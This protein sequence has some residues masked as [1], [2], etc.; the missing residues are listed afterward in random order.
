MHTYP[1][2]SS[3]NGG[4]RVPELAKDHLLILKKHLWTCKCCGFQSRPVKDNLYGYMVAVERTDSD[5]RITDFCLCALCHASHFVDHAFDQGKVTFIYLDRV[6]QKQLNVLTRT[7]MIAANSET[8]VSDAADDR[9]ND[10]AQLESHLFEQLPDYKGGQSDIARLF[11]TATAER[12]ETFQNL[13]P[14]IR[15][16]P[17]A[18]YWREE[19][20]Y[21]SEHAYTNLL[22]LNWMTTFGEP[23]VQP[24]E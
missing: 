24:A 14:G 23:N 5:N 7:L 15:V 9:L 2:P 6:S 21:W 19:V 20:S 18:Y 17:A 3:I 10:L 8:E 4:L 16:I 1:L 12:L 22:P 11:K 13:L